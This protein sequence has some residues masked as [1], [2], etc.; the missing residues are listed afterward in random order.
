MEYIVKPKIFPGTNSRFKMVPMVIRTQKHGR[1]H[2]R[3]AG[4]NSLPT[5]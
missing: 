5:Q 1:F 3:P 2:G 4:L